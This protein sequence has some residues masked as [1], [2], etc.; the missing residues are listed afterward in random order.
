VFEDEQCVNFFLNKLYCQNH[1]KT[2][3]ICFIL[4]SLCESQGGILKIINEGYLD[5]QKSCFDPAG[6]FRFFNIV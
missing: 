5:A 4:T 1:K 3:E 6:D 2:V